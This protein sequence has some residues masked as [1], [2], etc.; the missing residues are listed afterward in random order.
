MK[1]NVTKNKNK[2]FFP[3]SSIPIFLLEKLLKNKIEAITV[4]IKINSKAN[5]LKGLKMN[6]NEL[7]SSN[8]EAF[9]DDLKNS[10]SNIEF[11]REVMAAINT[12][13]SSTELNFNFIGL[14]ASG[15]SAG[16]LR[17]ILSFFFKSISFQVPA[18]KFVR[19]TGTKYKLVIIKVKRFLFLKFETK[20]TIREKIY[21]IISSE[22]MTSTSSIA[23]VVNIFAMLATRITKVDTE[24]DQN[25]ANLA[26]SYTHL[27][28]PTKRSV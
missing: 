10:L 6:D 17:A 5:I 26:V 8:F 23:P 25:K 27:T 22:K 20:L 28:L 12:A 14:N 1:T 4:I 16:L 3:N 24:R 11:K 13:P 2:T 7:F 21:T 15:K 19:T 9:S 18:L